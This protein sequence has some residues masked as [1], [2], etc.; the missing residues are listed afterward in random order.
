MSSYQELSVLL[1][2]NHAME[3]STDSDSSDD[4]LM[5]F[6]GKVTNADALGLCVCVSGLRSVKDRQVDVRQ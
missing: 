3:E 4:S 6:K 1:T 5:I 2:T